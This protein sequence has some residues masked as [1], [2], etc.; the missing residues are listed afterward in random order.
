MTIVALSPNACPT[1]TGSSWGQCGNGRS[2]Q[3]FAYK[4]LGRAE[5][6]HKSQDHT[7]TGTARGTT[8]SH[9]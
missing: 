8:L 9:T 2:P 4:H 5:S 3:G 7:G 1:W 6:E